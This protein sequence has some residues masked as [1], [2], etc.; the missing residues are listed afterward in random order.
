M[1]YGV[2]LTRARASS[3]RRDIASPKRK[4]LPI[5]ET[6]TNKVK[7][8]IARAQAAPHPNADGAT[9]LERFATPH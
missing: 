1:R 4:S 5:T 2:R 6:K 3:A 9:A 8:H 7:K